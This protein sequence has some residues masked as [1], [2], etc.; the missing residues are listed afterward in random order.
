MN[1]SEIEKLEVF[2][3][4]ESRKRDINVSVFHVYRGNFND[5]RLIES[6]TFK[7]SELEGKPLEWFDIYLGRKTDN[8]IKIAF[9]S[10]D[11]NVLY[12]WEDDGTRRELRKRDSFTYIYS[13][14]YDESHLIAAHIW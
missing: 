14:D 7:I 9:V 6:K 10:L 13:D 1:Q 4:N 11:E 8:K 2:T 12:F 3:V 5:E